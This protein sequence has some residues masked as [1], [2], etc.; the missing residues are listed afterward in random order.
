MAHEQFVVI[1][2]PE[3]E[4]LGH[5]PFVAEH[6]AGADLLVV[7]PVPATLSGKGLS[8]RVQDEVQCVYDDVLLDRVA[9]VWDRRP[10]TLDRHMLEPV[11]PSCRRYAWSAIQEHTRQFYA[12]FRDALWVSDHH[13]VQRA[14]NKVLQLAE[15]TKIGFNVPETIITSDPD[16]ARQFVTNRHAAIVKGLGGETPII[17]DTWLLMFSTKVTPDT[18]LDYDNLRYAPAIFQQAIDPEH[19]LRI[20]V[21]EDEVFPASVISDAEATETTGV[22]DWRIGNHL[23]NLSI[24]ECVL[25]DDVKDKCIQHVRRLGLR[26]GAIDMIRDKKGTYWF[27]EN[28]PNGQ[29]AFIEE[30]TRQPIGRAIARLLLSG[31]G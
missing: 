7:D 13:A 16:A 31:R 3:D 21:V 28:N 6:M 30:A 29:W 18:E 10:T 15:A 5:V 19:D 11:H 12:Q 14:E 17:G 26:F 1:T 2:G 8:Y 23:G 4:Q 27:I 9:A 20:T 22:R 24:T 25:P